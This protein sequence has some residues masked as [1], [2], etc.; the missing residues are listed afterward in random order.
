[1]EQRL[2]I[3]LVDDNP[4]DLTFFGRAAS[5]T[6]LNLRL[7]TLTAGQQAIDYLNAKGEY[8]DRSKYPWPDV[9]VVDLRMIEVNGFDFLAWRKSSAL[10]SSIPVILFSGSN[11]PADIKRIFELGGNKHIVKPASLENWEKVVREI[12]EI[13]TQGTTFSSIEGRRQSGAR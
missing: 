6:G 13:G 2:E 8:S 1:M 4:V 12:W 10:V 11:E 7:Q 9:I 5:K 3:L